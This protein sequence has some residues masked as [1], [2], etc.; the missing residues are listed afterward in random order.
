VGSTLGNVL[1]RLSAD[2][3]A[4]GELTAATG[5]LEHSTRAA[6]TGSGGPLQSQQHAA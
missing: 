6:L 2:A 3:G 5:W 1:D 4:I